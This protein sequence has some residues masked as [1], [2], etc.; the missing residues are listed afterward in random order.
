MVCAACEE[1]LCLLPVSDVS[2][3]GRPGGLVTDVQVFYDDLQEAASD[4]ADAAFGLQEDAS[5][6]VGDDS[7]IAAPVGRYELKT[8][9]DRQIDLLREVTLTHQG[10]SAA[11]RTTMSNIT[12]RYS[13]LDVELTGE[14]QR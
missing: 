7:G 3:F 2:D 13:D 5:A 6:L 4:L 9:F 8:A 12:D 11:L 1:Q 10:S 14:E